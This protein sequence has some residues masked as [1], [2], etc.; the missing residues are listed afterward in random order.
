MMRRILGTLGWVLAYG[1]LIA[2]AVVTLLPLYWMVTGAFK[3]GAAIAQMPPQWWPVRPVLDNF[4][5]LL[6][7]PFWRWMGNSLF[8]A[9]VVTLTNVLFSAMAGYAFA[10]LRFPGRDKLFWLMLAAIMIPGEVTLIPN[11]L[12]VTGTLGWKDTY[13]ALIVPGAVNIGS[14]FLV[15]QFMGTLP[16]TLLDAARIDGCSEFRIWYRVILPMAR[17]VLAVLAI[18]TFVGAYNNFFWPLLV[19][20]KPELR[21]IQVGLAGFRFENST[22]YGAITAGATLAAIPIAILFVAFQKHFLKGV[23]VGALKG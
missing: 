12:L 23:T 1:V 7:R 6:T 5:T 15:K 18:F 20:N 8:V 10:K 3:G 14:I 13:L 9:A 21:M 2:W 22:D 11:Y 4:H 17:P 16:G 19:A